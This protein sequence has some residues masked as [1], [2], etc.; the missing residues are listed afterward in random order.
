M[1]LFHIVAR[2]PLLVKAARPL[3]S[4]P[5]QVDVPLINYPTRRNNGTQLPFTAI[6]REVSTGNPNIIVMGA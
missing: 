3:L 5:R 2:I 6:L 4:P 1:S